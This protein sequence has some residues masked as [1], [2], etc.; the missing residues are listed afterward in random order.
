M[1]RKQLAYPETQLYEFNM[2]QFQ[3]RGIK[4]DDIIDI[5]IWLQAKF[6]PT[7]DRQNYVKAL[8][9]ILHKIA[10]MNSLAVGFV[11]DD[12]AT[13]KK[14]P[15]P[16]QTIIGED[17]AYFDVDEHLAISISS[18]YGAI[19]TTNFGYLDRNKYGKVK[20]LDQDSTRVNTFADD[21]VGALATATGAKVA[22]DNRKK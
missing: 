19:G 20:E 14:L 16:L 17:R 18:L 8:E 13:D 3:K 5:A 9:Q 4:K 22:F 7:V 1:D 15:E 11:L 6:N 2:Q 10:V 12:L 21:L